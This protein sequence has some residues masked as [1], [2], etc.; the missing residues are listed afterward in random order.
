MVAD[1][2]S[3]KPLPFATIK[4]GNKQGA[5]LTGIDG[6]FTL[7]IN[8]NITHI[9]IS[10]VGHDP[11]K[12]S[13][14]EIK[15]EDTIFLFPSSSNLKEFTVLPQNEKIRHII[16]MAI[17]NKPLNN[18]ELYDE[19]QCKIYYKMFADILP[20]TKP[21]KDSIAGV[22]PMGMPNNFNKKPNLSKSDSN[23][24]LNFVANNHLI[25]SET[26]SKRSYRRPKQL[27]EDVLASRFSGIKKTYFTF[28]VTDVLPFHV[29]GDY[30]SLNSID[31]I[32]PIAKGWQQR[33][34]FHLLDELYIDQDTVFLLSFQPKKNAAFNSLKG[35]VYINSDGYAISNFIASTS[36][37]SADREAR[38][39]QKYEKV[40]DKWFPKE[41]NYQLILKKMPSPAMGTLLNGHSMISDVE[42][43][44]DGVRFNKAHPVKLGDSVDLHTEN[45]WA[46]LRPDTLDR[47]EK[48]TYRVLDSMA[49]KTNLEKKL[50]ALGKITVG[51]IGIGKFD[52]DINRI[53]VFNQYEKTRLGLGLSTNDKVSKYYSLGGWAGFGT[54]DSRWKYGAS[55]T[56]YPAGDKENW[57]RF[58]YQDNYQ[59]AGNVNIHP[60]LDQLGFRNWLLYKVDRIKEIALTGST[61]LG[62]WGLQVNAA[63]QDLQSF[64]DNQFLFGG[65]NI[66]S[67][68]INQIG[69]GIKYAYGERRIPM[70]GYYVPYSTQFP[71]AYFR[72]D[73]GN[74]SSGNY[75]TNYFRPIAA[76]TYTKHFNRW[77]NDKFQLE[78]AA[79]LTSNQQPLSRSFLLA[80]KGFN[81]NIFNYYAW[82]GFLTMYPYDYFS[83]HYISLFYKHDFD[84]FL[85]NMKF[86]KPFI[87]IA[88]NMIY[89]GL[90]TQNLT[91]N[92]AIA[93]PK[94]GYHES[95]L[96]LN[97]LLTWN[98]LHLANIY[99]NGGVFYHW[100]A[101]NNWS[102]NA[103][104][105][106]GV[107]IGF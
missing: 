17:K 26:Y 25:F 83:D 28:L 76:L 56:I 75:S 11:K 4:I 57:I 79:I 71:I 68:H 2:I 54:H 61:Q 42:F 67:F 16:N 52:L 59:S 46:Q 92:T 51:K 45:E 72:V 49:Q 101:Q 15:K 74:I 65:K 31:Y 77:G 48:N 87:S 103:V 1:S 9:S 18:P 96:L 20:N 99:F 98:Y 37:S 80:G 43:N 27:Q 90:N 29:Y 88:H 91:T 105:V 14:T 47:K 38:I 34:R 44:N 86:S 62:Y 33:Y 64:Y 107:S 13:V 63:T 106:A 23:A 81:N 19:Y 8:P 84:K 35:L 50:S 5:I 95:G 24:I 3:K 66:S 22:P 6:Y 85:W 93:A 104:W 40:G 78:A 55:A 97:Q 70:F 21:I 89:G 82:G 32:N 100:N 94:N 102:Q 41:L 36:D 12:L 7:H 10:Y 69:I 73:A 39:E 53:V 30:I 60:E 58:S